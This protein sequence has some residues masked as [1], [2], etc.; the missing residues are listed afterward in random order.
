MAYIFLHF[1]C[2]ICLKFTVFSKYFIS[3][4]GGGCE[5]SSAL[6]MTKCVLYGFIVFLKS[7][8]SVLFKVGV[9][10]TATLMLQ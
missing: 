6:R 7:L 1:F 5:V 3:S 8:I 9:I 2:V 4:A 10:L